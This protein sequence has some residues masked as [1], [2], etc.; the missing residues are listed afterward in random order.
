MHEFPTLTRDYLDPYPGNTNDVCQNCT[1]LKRKTPN[2]FSVNGNSLVNKLI[3]HWLILI[4]K[5]MIAW[6][7]QELVGNLRDIKIVLYKDLPYIKNSS[8]DVIHFSVL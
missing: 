5:K 4:L 1:S 7:K 8:V 3:T 6:K 2:S